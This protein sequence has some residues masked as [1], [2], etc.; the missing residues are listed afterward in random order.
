MK[1][2]IRLSGTFVLSGFLFSVTGLGATLVIQGGGATTEL[3]LLGANPFHSTEARVTHARLVEVPGSALLLALW[4]EQDAGGPL[5]PHYAFSFDGQTFRSAQETSY[6]IGLS[7][8]P[9]DPL[10]GVPTVPPSLR[11]DPSG[12]LFIVQFVTQPLE[13]FRQEIVRL[14]GTVYG[15]LPN[16][17]QIVRMDEATRK[18][19]ETLPYVRWVG[20]YHPAYRLEA[21][22]RENLDQADTLFPLQVYNI[23][24]F[25]SGPAQ[26]KLVAEQIERLGGIIEVV[27]DNGFLLFARLTPD[28]LLSVIRWDEIAFVDR[29]A[30]PGLAMNI[31]RDRHISGANYVASVSAGSY[32]GAGVRGE[33]MDTNLE[34]GHVAFQSIPPILHGPQAGDHYHGT[35]VYGCGF[36]DGTGAGIAGAKGVIPQAQGIFADFCRLEEAAADGTTTGPNC[37]LEFTPEERVDRYEHTAELVDPMGPLKAVFQ[38]NSWGTNAGSSYSTMSQEMDDILFQYDLLVCQAQDNAGTTLSKFEAW[39]KNIV[40]VGGVHHYDTVRKN[41]DRWFDPNIYPPAGT[42]LNASIGPASDNRIKPDFT[43]F[44]DDVYTTYVGGSSYV[45]VFYGT[46]AAT[47]IT[48][49]HFGLFF[50]MWADGLFGNTLLDPNCNPANE[51]CVFKNRPHMTTA[52]A[53]MINTASPYPFVGSAESVDFTRTHQGWGLVQVGRLHILRSRFPIIV[54]ETQVLTQASSTAT[55]TVTVPPNTKA[56]RATLVYADPPGIPDSTD[57]SVPKRHAVNDLNLKLTRPNSGVHYWGNCG[58][59]QGNWSS[60][61]CIDTNQLIPNT[62]DQPVVIDTVEN[63]FVQNPVSGT[64]TV[65]VFASQIAGDG[66]LETPGVN[67]VD[68]AL[69]VSIDLDCNTNGVSDADDIL[70]DPPVSLDC[71]NN[72]IPDSCDIATGTSCDGDNNGVPDECQQ[73]VPVGACCIDGGPPQVCVD[74][75]QCACD[76]LYGNFAGVGTQCATT[77][78]LI[79]PNLVQPVGPDP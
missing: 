32:S 67:D 37:Q 26:K 41:D 35:S 20:P 59:R 49:G 66:R 53:M 8:P 72:S 74:T 9:F 30:P 17:S 60:N 12:N 10:E 40:S 16:N 51:N 48:C 43:H 44:L 38:S 6:E 33:I 75:T 1:T 50:E 65:Q 70:A 58:L 76:N 54:N 28:Q 57:P 22:L 78:C 5:V 14:G 77:I 46:S 25:E 42:P 4:D 13:E 15:F 69:V 47:P 73:P 27:P 3:A 34:T 31:A 2:G 52:K 45:P 71:N 21:F 55:S 19:V 29:W 7:S 61:G 39:A 62:P 11:A 36:G 18:Q 63:V 24:V 79:I 68:F 23:A 64:W 56:L